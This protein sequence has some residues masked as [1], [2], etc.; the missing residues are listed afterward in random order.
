MDWFTHF[1]LGN[2]ILGKH[3]IQMDKNYFHFENNYK[4]NPNA[5]VHLLVTDSRGFNTIAHAMAYIC[6]DL[7][8]QKMN[9][10]VKN[11]DKIICPYTNL[12]F[13]LM[14]NNYLNDSVI[15]KKGDILYSYM[16]PWSYIE[17]NAFT[18]LTLEQRA[19]LRLL[20]VGVN[21]LIIIQQS[22]IRRFLAIRKL[23][24]MKFHNNCLM[25]FRLC[26]PNIIEHNNFRTFQG[27]DVY[28]NSKESFRMLMV[29]S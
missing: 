12:L 4:S 27:G 7:L 3:A 10:N 21:R 16:T 26:P 24:K 5:Y 22:Y 13:K 20:K 8:Y 29:D 11:N 23:E 18:N 15:W 19:M 25:Q 9:G 28:L 6:V 2:P 17:R 14:Y 1:E